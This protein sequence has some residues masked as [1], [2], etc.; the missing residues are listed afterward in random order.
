MSSNT[1]LPSGRA[2]TVEEW[3]MEIERAVAGY[4][5]ADL[6]YLGS[7]DEYVNVA[8]ANSID[9]LAARVSFRHALDRVMQSWHPNPVTEWMRT[10]HLLE[11]LR[12]WT[13]AQGS[14]KTLDLMTRW[15]AALD[16][17]QEQARDR[18]VDLRKR[19]L[20]VLERY[21][22]RPQPANPVFAE[23][24]TLLKSHLQRE[25]FRVYAARRLRDLGVVRTSDDSFIDVVPER[26]LAIAAFIDLALDEAGSDEQA[27]LSLVSIYTQCNAYGRSNEF[28]DAIKKLGGVFH[29]DRDRVIELRHQKYPLNLSREHIFDEWERARPALTKHISTI[30]EHVQ[31]QSENG[32]RR[33]LPFTI[34]QQ[35]EE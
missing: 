11:L 23:Y 33:D 20:S 10:Y 26:A 8:I 9:P 35:R 32:T 16:R 21:F 25:R 12:A 24:V 29:K 13:P 2:P 14:D 4:R 27:A 7:V 5:D 18:A 31:H 1:S 30:D 22:P 17:E 15:S 6:R 34:P 3:E 19:A 28:E